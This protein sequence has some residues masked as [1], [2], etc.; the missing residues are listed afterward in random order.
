MSSADDVTLR[1]LGGQP[2]RRPRHRGGDL[3]FFRLLGSL[4]GNTIDQQFTIY[5]PAHILYK[6][7]LHLSFQSTV[8]GTT[9]S[10]AIFCRYGQNQRHGQQRILSTSEGKR[11]C[12]PKF[13]SKMFP[14]KTRVTLPTEHSP[15]APS[16]YRS[17]HTLI[18]GR[19]YDL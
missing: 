3:R 6:C 4:V 15:L 16:C 5:L 7:I 8:P 11:K 12:H 1:Q 19:R 9:Y 13:L 18:Q 17:Q 10:L 14:L 2:R